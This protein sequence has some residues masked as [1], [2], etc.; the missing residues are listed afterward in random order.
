MI[1]MFDDLLGEKEPEITEVDKDALIRA[2]ADNIK[3]KQDMINDL[4]RQI[5]ELER[6]IESQEAGVI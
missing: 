4:V 3:Q 2:M 1:S 5:T 6:Q